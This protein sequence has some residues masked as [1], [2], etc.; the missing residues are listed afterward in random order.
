MKFETSEYSVELI[1]E[2]N[3]LYDSSE[4]TSSYLFKYNIEEEFQ[5]SSVYGVR[6]RQSDSSCLIS[7]GGGASALTKYSAIIRNSELWII[8]GD[9]MVCLEL[10]SLSLKWKQKVDS[11]TCF[12]L[13]PS[14]DNEGLIIHGELE[15]S[16]VSF[17]GDILWSTSGKD[18]FSG[19]FR[20]YDDYVE[21]IDFNGEVYRISV[22]DGTS[23]LLQS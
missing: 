2:S 13:F 10:P 17:T 1:D 16:K 6:C 22:K 18:I 7:S 4:N 9:Q 5:P 8:V 3:R 20:V 19:D 21:A 14:P 23:E 12:Q 15:I 11:A